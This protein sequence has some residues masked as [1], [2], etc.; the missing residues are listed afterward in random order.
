MSKKSEKSAKSGK[1]AKNGVADTVAV[2]EP[3]QPMP[4][5]E[6]DMTPE[7]ADKKYILRATGLQKVFDEGTFNVH[8]L[9]GV[10]LRVEPGERVAI[11]GASGSGKSTLLHLLGGLDRPT[12]GQV[13]IDGQDL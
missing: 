9:R 7:K 1:A 11:V 5:P 2:A 3:P 12:A 6:P 13:E 10:Y 8:V 4:A